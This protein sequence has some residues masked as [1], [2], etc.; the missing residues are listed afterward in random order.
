MKNAA[1]TSGARITGSEDIFCL[2][3]K[4]GVVVDLLT[5]VRVGVRVIAGVGVGVGGVG[6]GVAE[7]ADVEASS[8]EAGWEEGVSTTSSSRANSPVFV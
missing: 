5:G 6:I 8:M 3:C 2:F 1:I 4:V 7:V